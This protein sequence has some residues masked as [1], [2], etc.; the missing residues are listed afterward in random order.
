MN[1]GPAPSLPDQAPPAQ[2][3]PAIPLFDGGWQRNLMQ[4]LLILIL[5]VSLLMGPIALMRQI[6]GEQRFLALLPFFFFVI[7]QAIYSRRWLAR[8]EHRWFG[9]PRA[10]LG[11]IVLVLTLLRLVIWLIQRQPITL[12]RAR[13]WL[14]EPISFFDPLFVLSA[15]LALI[16]W[17]FAAS[18]T[19]LFLDLALAPDELMVWEGRGG[20]RAWVQA[21]PKNR[22]ELLERY[23]GQWMWG[24]VLLTFTAAAARI[25]LRPG[26][27]RL[28]GL[29]ALG[30][31]P[32][33]VLALALYF[34]IG[35]LLLSYGQLATLRARWQ[36]EG[37]PGIDQVTGRWQRN[38]L[39]TIL[40][41]GLLA[42]LLPLGSSFGL[43]LLLNALFQ[44]LL[45]IASF[46][47]TLVAAL[48]SWA[49]NLFGLE[50]SVAPELPPAPFQPDF[51]PPEP[52]PPE[53]VLPPWAAG[54]V[55]WLLLILVALYLL[56]YFFWRQGWGRAVLQMGWFARLQQWWRLFW[57]RAHAVAA[58][59]RARL[60]AVSLPATSAALPRPW[61]FVR[62]LGLSPTARARYFYLSTLRRAAQAG[63]ARAPAQTPLEYEQ[64]LA[65][66]LPTAGAEIDDLTA[67]FLR[68]RYAPTPLEEP[69][70]SRAQSAAA[71][72]KQHLR[73][74]GGEQ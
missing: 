24:G 31:G 62:L 5:T 29:T 65:E 33:L 19:T 74:L 22:Q 11:E 28:F 64:T 48:I 39:L 32:E 10:R 69:A 17:G 7:L 13:G 47:L 61:R 41:V 49:L 15:G 67:S 35:L 73:R 12:E 34:L 70:A 3:L 14:V 72:I 57:T 20:T 1:I 6:S 27:G 23:A 63:V 30:L 38:A 66:R 36:R 40:G 9:D 54:G 43:A 68:A 4:P 16:A 56:F 71:R 37:T 50:S 25:E 45:F 2:P 53:S 55:F 52:A 44:A 59:A 8:P 42:S 51:L 18:L 58:Q 21:Q 26:S 46:L 60:A